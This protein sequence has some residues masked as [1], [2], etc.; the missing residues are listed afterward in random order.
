MP[1]SKVSDEKIAVFKSEIA[2]KAADVQAFIIANDE[3][4]QD[5]LM[6]GKESQVRIKV[7][8]EYFA[9]DIKR[10]NDLHKSLT[11]KRKDLIDPYKKVVQTA[12]DKIG[13]YDKDVAD[14]KAV[15]EAKQQQKEVDAHNRRIEVA[16]KKTAELLDGVT[17][18]THQLSLLTEKLEEGDCTDDEAEVM[19][20]QIILLETAIENKKDKVEVITEKVEQKAPVM[21]APVS[22]AKPTDYEVTVTDPVALCKA[23]GDGHAPEGLVKD[24]NLVDLKK[25][26]KLGQSYPG[27][28]YKPLYKKA[29]L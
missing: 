22:K 8:E 5:V 10:A 6:I 1:E 19:R 12:K 29:R 26:K 27:V 16:R 14:K 4:R 7:I 28:N 23:I 13:E 3:G 18:L 25:F 24:F 9:D 11:G 15:E 17:D 20:E 2:K 21:S